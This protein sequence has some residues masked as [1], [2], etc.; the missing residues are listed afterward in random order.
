MPE[1]VLIVALITLITAIPTAHAQEGSGANPPVSA[2]LK[3]T[4]GFGTFSGALRGPYHP[5]ESPEFKK[6]A[7][8]GFEIIFKPRSRI[9]FGGD[10]F[11]ADFANT[12]FHQV[13]VQDSS[14]EGVNCGQAPGTICGASDSSQSSRITYAALGNVYVNLGPSGARI[15][16]FVGGGV[17][18]GRFEINYAYKI[19]LFHPIYQALTQS[20]ESGSIAVA[21]GVAGLAG[22]ITSHIAIRAEGGWRHGGYA[23]IGLSFQ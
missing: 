15:Q 11:R 21:K 20:E 14:D 8:P 1:R 13:I 19:M 6:T 17:G 7:E 12:G 18:I 10:F 9:S 16:P 3:A 22:Y 23:A 5:L 4:M 2:F